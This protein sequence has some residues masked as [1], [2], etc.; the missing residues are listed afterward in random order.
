ME[1]F[2]KAKCIRLKSNHEK[3]LHA[4]PDQESVYQ[5]RSGS[6]KSVKWT[7]EF[8]EGLD[9]VIRLKSCYGKYLTA[10]DEQHLFGVTGQK[11]V[12]SLPNKLDSLVEWEP[13][14]EGS[15]VKLKTRYGNYLR[16]N[17]GLPP[18]R[19][20]VTHDIPHRH[21]DWILWAVDTVEVLLELPDESVSESGDDDL[22]SSFHLTTPKFSRTQSTLKSEGRLIYFYV[23]DENGNVDDSVKGPS[24]QF[25][26]HGLD[27]LTKKL[28]EE[29]GIEKIVVCS[30]NKFNG[31]LYPLRL[32]LPPNNATMHVV[33][34][35]AS[36]KVIR[37]GEKSNVKG[38]DLT[39]NGRVRPK[40]PGHH[41]HRGS[42]EGGKR[43]EELLVV[44]G[45]GAA[46]IY[47]AIRA[48]ALAP[49][50]QVV[51]IEKAKPLSKVK[52]SGGGRC[53]VTNGHCPDNKIEKDGRVFPTSDS[54]S[55]VIDC[56]MSE[57][58]RSGGGRDLHAGQ[59]EG[60]RKRAKIVHTCEE[61][62]RQ[63][64]TEELRETG[65]VVT[66][67]S[68]T[69]DGK[70]AVKLEKRSL[71]YVE[72]VEA[73]YLLIASGSSKQGYNLATQLGHSIVEPV[74]SLFTFKIDDL[75]L[76]ELSGLPKAYK[77]VAKRN[78]RAA[79]GAEVRE[80]LSSLMSLMDIQA[81]EDCSGLCSLA[82]EEMISL[83][84]VTCCYK[85]V[86]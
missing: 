38:E 56:L 58:K 46:G 85:F 13:I 37:Q 74:P 83:V 53:N 81:N 51:V 30:R 52:I 65:K 20:S 12:Q 21:Q 15:L 70:F 9:N 69:S 28:E 57:A 33:V 41:F 32:A 67:A 34:L 14:K 66:G 60:S 18:W 31:N 29:T 82:L 8:P 22:G 19:N 11:V 35:P 36:S 79:H 2:Q 49:N 47:G 50:L 16:A 10:L 71:D 42:G 75:K 54:S 24:F 59:N 45:G 23:A 72:H 84:D 76:A 64:A 3:F 7:V 44:V 39:A 27:E 40:H 77:F 80:H 78:I 17:S 4:D 1:F 73:D 5:D 61:E 6:S 25:K 26:G 62:V 68:S 43:G 63:Y 48:K 55:T 86:P